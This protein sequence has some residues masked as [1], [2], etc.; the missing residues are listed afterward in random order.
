[1]VKVREGR[2]VQTGPPTSVGRDVRRRAWRPRPVVAGDRGCQLLGW[3]CSTISGAAGSRAC[4][5]GES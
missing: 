1:M 4:S 2:S 5:A 3:Q